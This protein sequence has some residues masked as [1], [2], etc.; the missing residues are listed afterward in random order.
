MS[1]MTCLRGGV[2]RV[3]AVLLVLATAAGVSRV[4]AQAPLVGVIAGTASGPAGPLAG[5]TVNVVNAAGTLV[6]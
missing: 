4:N 2:T 5:V 3:T 1:H 6:G